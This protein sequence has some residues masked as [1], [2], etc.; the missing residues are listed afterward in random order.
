[1]TQFWAFPRKMRGGHLVINSG[2]DNGSYMEVA[3]EKPMK[4][5]KH[6]WFIM[7]NSGG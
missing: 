3:M 1:M 5:V 7:I 2:V 6:G 4:M